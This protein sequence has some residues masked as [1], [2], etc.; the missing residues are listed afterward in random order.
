MA[1]TT[2]SRL[3]PVLT[4]ALTTT[5]LALTGSTAAAQQPQGPPPCDG[6]SF[7]A[8]DYW[9]GSWIVRNAEGQQVGTNRVSTI[10]NGCGILEEWES[11]TGSTGKSL[12][13]YEPSSGDWRQVWVGAGGS[14]LDLRGGPVDGV[15]TLQQDQTN[16]QGETVR[17]RIQWI[18]RDG[19]VV[20]QLWEQSN[21]GGQNWSVAFQGFYHPEG[22]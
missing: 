8:F 1:R 2:R 12:N 16:A 21:D 19:G 17:Q 11:A 4:A 3:R 22:R 18:P 6:E 15:M 9:L 13:F 5:A 20:E 14:I 7:E 10:S